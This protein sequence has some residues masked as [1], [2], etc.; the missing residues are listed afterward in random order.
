[1]SPVN[2]VIRD[3]SRFISLL[4]KAGHSVCT[5]THMIQDREMQGVTLSIRKHLTLQYQEK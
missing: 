4:F 2:F 3:T 5:Y 1:M